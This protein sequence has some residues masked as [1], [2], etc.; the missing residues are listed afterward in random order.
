MSEWKTYNGTDEQIE[1]MR[2]AEH[3]IIFKYWM[4][5]QIVESKIVSHDEINNFLFANKY[6]THYLIC[7]PH[8]QDDMIVRQAHTGQP[9]WI[10]VPYIPATRIGMNNL[11]CNDTH[12]F[13]STTCPDWYADGAEYSFTPFSEK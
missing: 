12:C 13:Y 2:N 7:N 8:P 4:M 11:H 1:E 10:K 9:V 5:A 6:P 3:G